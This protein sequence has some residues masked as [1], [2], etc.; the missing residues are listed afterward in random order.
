MSL[1][2]AITV[3]QIFTLSEYL[4]NVMEKQDEIDVK[5]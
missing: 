5:L 2:E 4:L 1:K 3:H